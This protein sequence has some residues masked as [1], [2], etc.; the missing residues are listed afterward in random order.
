MR[1][2]CC[3]LK[4]SSDEKREYFQMNI[5]VLPRKACFDRPRFTHLPS[6]QSIEMCGKFYR[7]P[8]LTR[9]LARCCILMTSSSSSESSVPATSSSWLGVAP[10]L[11][12]VV[13][14][15]RVLWFLQC[16][17]TRHESYNAIWNRKVYGYAER[18]ANKKNKRSSEVAWGW[19]DLLFWLTGW[20][21]LVGEWT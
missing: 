17:A 6:H 8:V 4:N 12:C 21:G 1:W 16:D 2:K 20:F 9:I 3:Q 14:S 10:I 5:Q 7:K 13:C 18:R 15:T 19:L 11:C